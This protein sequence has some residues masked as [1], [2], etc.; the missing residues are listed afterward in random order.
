M[1][2]FWPFKGDDSSAASFEKVLSQLSTKINKANAQNDSFRQKQRRYKVLWTL[3]STFAYI[4][5]AAILTLVTGYQRW[6]V[7][8]Y[9]AVAGSPVLIFGVRTALDAY[10]NYR[11]SHS[12][13]YLNDL[14]KQRENAIL[15]LKSATKYDSTQQLLDKYGGGSPRQEQSSPRPLKKRKSEGGQS[16]Q[17]TPQGQRTGFAP[18]P[19]AN[20]Q[21]PPGAGPVTPQ[22]APGQPRRN[23]SG[24]PPESEP[25]MQ[26]SNEPSEEF[27]PNAFSMPSRSPP[28]MPQQSQQYHEGAKWYDRIFDVVL[29]EDETQAKNRIALICQNCRLVNGQAPPG[30]RTLEDVGRWRCSS[31]Q[32]WNGVESEEKRILQR[33]TGGE[34]E[35]RSPVSPSNAISEMHERKGGS[36]GSDSATYEHIEEELGGDEDEADAGAVEAPPTG[37]TRSKARQRRKA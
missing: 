5:V 32:A 15:R 37:S 35:M 16:N 8:E 30:A 14:V 29:G 3:Y 23:M 9:T 10:Y 7:P 4:L 36:E 2:S 19:T 31:C 33:I 25:S 26:A 22:G 20:I 11:L 12:Q 6:S 24:M 34:E 1:V 18:P 13:T 27:A 17:S 28:I 21:R